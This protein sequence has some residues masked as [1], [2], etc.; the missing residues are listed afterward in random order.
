MSLPLRGSL[1]QGSQSLFG[2]KTELQFGHLRLTAIASQQRSE[3]NDITIQGGSVLQEFEV[4]IDQYVENRHFFLSHFNRES[5]EMALA[6]LPQIN[7]LF[8]ITR[9]EVWVTNDKNQTTDVRD[10]V[11]IAD[12]GES[13]RI[14]DGN[15]HFVSMM[16]TI[17]L[18]DICMLNVLPANEANTILRELGLNPENRFIENVNSS[19]NAIG[20]RSTRDYEKIRARRLSPAEYTYHPELG[21]ISLNTRL[22]SDH[23]VGIAYEYTYNG[24]QY[25]VGEL[26]DIIPVDAENPSVI[27]VKMLKSTTQRIDLPIWDLMM[28]NFYRVG[29][30]D[31]NPEEFQLDVFYEDPGAGFKRFLPSETGIGNTP[32]ITL[33]NLD[34]LNVTGDPQPDGR[35]DFVPGL[36]IYPR[37]GLLMFPVL[38]PF[39]SSLENILRAAGTQEQFIQSVI[40]P[41]LYDSTLIRAQEFPEF[42][43]FTI[44]GKSQSSSSS[45]IS[46]G[47][48]NIPRGSVQ[49]YAGGQ[50]LQENVDYVIDYNIGRLSIL[51]A[52]YVQP[53]TPIRVSFEDNALF[54]FQKKTMLG[55]RADYEVNKH[56]NIGAT[57]MHL[58]ERPYTEKVNI[59]DDP[60]NNR[61]MGLDLTY[62]KEAPWITKLVDKLPVINTKEPSMLN[63][64]AEVAALKPGHSRAINGGSEQKEGVVYIDDFEGTASEFDL[65]TPETRWQLASVPQGVVIE[66]MPRFA[67]SQFHDSLVSG[68]NRAHFNWYR[69]D[70]SVRT[71][72][73]DNSNPYT[74]AVNQQEI[75]RG[76]TQRFGNN[77]FRTFDIHYIPFERGPYNFDPPQG[78]APYSAGINADC[79]LNNPAERWGGIQRDIPNTDFE[80]SNYEALEFWMLD[81]YIHAPDSLGGDGYLVINLGNVSEDI[82]KDG[83]LAYEHGLPSDT[84]QGQTDTTMWGRVPRVQPVVNAFSI[85]VN[86]RIAQDVG[87]DGF[88]DDAERTFYAD[89]VN[90]IQNSLLPQDCKDEI[91]SDP[92]NDNFLYFRDPIF[93]ADAGILQRYSRFNGTEGNSPPTPQSNDN[94]LISANTNRPNS[95][96]LNDD[97]SLSDG[98]EAYYQYI[99]KMQRGPDGPV[100]TSIGKEGELV[101]WQLDTITSEASGI[102]QTW[103]RFKVPLNDGLAVNGIQGFR[104]IRFMRMYMTGFDQK[105]ILRFATLDLVRSQWRRYTRATDQECA[106]DGA[107][108]FE[109]DAVNVEEHSRKA[110]FPYVLPAGIRRERIIGSTFQ[111]VFQNEQSLALQFCDLVDGCDARIYKT[112][113]LDMRVFEQL[114]MF[115]HAESNEILNPGNPIQNGDLNLFIR[116]GSDF[117]N[118]YYEYE[119][120]LTVS[121]D[122]MAS[123]LAE[124]IWKPDSNNVKFAF[125]E[126]TDLK[127]ER[128][129]A[130]WPFGQEYVQ[131]VMIDGQRYTLKVKGNPTLGYVKNVM[132]GIRNPDG[133]NIAP[134]CGEVWVNELRVSGLDERGGVAALARIDMDLADFGTFGASATYSS[135]GYGAIDEKLDQRAKESTF[136]FDV[137]TG[138]E[139]GQF[140]GKEAGIKIPFY[141]Q[142]STTIQTPRFDP[143][144]LDLDL[145]EKLRRQTDPAV[146]DSIKNQ[147]EDFQALRVINFTNVKK[148]RKGTG[149]PM[150]W[151]VS[152]FSVSYSYSKSEAHNEIV[153]KD[154]LEQHKGQLDYNY[155]LPTVSLQPFKGLSDSKWL[156]PITEL[157]LNPLP[158]SFSFNTVLDR[159]FGERDYRFSDEIFKKWFDKRYTW[160]RNYN[161]R[162]D[163]TKSLKFDF[164]ATNASV[165]DEPDEY[166]DRNNLILIDKSVRRDSVWQNLKQFGRTKD[167]MHNVRA[168]Y[169]VPTNHFPFLDWIRADISYDAQYAW[170]SS[171]INTDSLGNVIRNGQNRKFTADL[172]FT[173]LYNKSKFL[174]KINGRA[175]ASTPKQTDPRTKLPQ[176]KKDAAA[177]DPDDPDAKDADPKDAKKDARVK[178]D[179]GQPGT[180]ARVLLRPLMTVRR[181]RVNY[182]QDFTT[183]VPGFTPTAGL[184]GMRDF[185]APGWGF[186][187]GQQPEIGR[188]EQSSGDWLDEN[189]FAGQNWITDNAFQN[190]PVL[191]SESETLDGKL[192]LEPFTDFKIEVDAKRTVSNNFSLFYKDVTK[193][194]GDNAF[195]RR[196]PREIGSFSMSYFTLPTLFGDSENELRRLFNTFENYRTDIS[197]QRGEPGTMHPIDGPTYTEGFGSKQR[198]VIIPAFIAAYTGKSPDNFDLDDMFGWLPRPNWQLTYSGLEK[199]GPFKE[200]FSSVRISHGYKST[201]NVNSFETD[202]NYTPPQSNPNNVNEATQNYYSR[203]I[204]PAVGIEEQFA[205]LIGID[206]RTKN[207]LNFQLEFAKRRGLQLGFISS[208][209]AENRV[210]SFQVGLDYVLK[211]I[212]LKFLPG[213]KANRED[214]K[215]P[216]SRGGNQPNR[217]GSSASS[218]KGNDLE[219]LFDFSFSDNITVNHYLDLN[220]QPQPTRGQKELTISPAIR[221]NLNK[222]INLRLFFDYR[223]TTPYT[224]TGYPITTTE[225]GITVQVILE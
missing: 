193:E 220:I 80:L 83:R 191:Q 74:R 28:K 121:D 66:S 9:M 219:I 6:N 165:I 24:I 82:L 128:N 214:D 209:L 60:I 81:P 105:T 114:E 196:S 94:N 135:V 211:N 64:Q 76:R 168:S 133:G 75:F 2:I 33:L 223:K 180:F 181:L 157:N 48:F 183:V 161:L 110:P 38:E 86:T 215:A 167:Y 123:D 146:R 68:V 159:R 99:I 103:Y 67:E 15:E 177:A 47:T 41:H 115:V 163:L 164:N 201:L 23:V 50:R 108:S 134:L 212:E 198:D 98:D 34:N 222:N 56:M 172:D 54:S 204:I 166:V 221:Y 96:D 119:L 77:D 40:Y 190:L 206:I 16:D 203:Y 202:L 17:A 210:T 14:S 19:M 63:F 59:G 12:L 44:K 95:E 144:D 73:A 132:I 88:N 27:Y 104:S 170:N 208:E 207:D 129:A 3:K 173:R 89:Y 187:F 97:L 125:K 122:P 147:A 65:R 189:G 127:I 205:P 37:E 143:I 29:G 113:N 152:N 53:G 186:I 149:P 150:P 49:V 51:N 199:L 145:K 124:E 109:V 26:S 169:K 178:K 197:Q 72:S 101:N 21:F 131:S 141:A 142:Y 36:T 43:R 87:L 184:L 111:D 100:F 130:M 182:S 52:S 171:S 224:T 90:S 192:T 84:A 91:I 153:S 188:F 216:P 61:V 107:L 31:V 174:G 195:E 155:T 176:N 69:V 7:S 126:L 85:D 158:N 71:S 46:L 151:S 218:L 13:R 58:F 55:L 10:V 102:S 118:N 22:Q 57:Y 8:R 39:G 213:F 117:E 78:V 42:N 136:Q 225:G 175:G 25:Q 116:L 30:G 5:F 70:R 18:K 79:E 160:D 148:E 139:L 1:I 112:L 154:D 156:K 92:S 11:A 120:P 106:L 45:D 200:I 194:H 140:F 179:D 35:F 185:S 20:L 217:G 62:S 32:L 162:W 137:S 138:L 4:P 93:P